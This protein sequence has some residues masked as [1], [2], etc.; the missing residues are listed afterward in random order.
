MFKFHKK[1]LNYQQERKNILVTGGAGFI[2][3]HLCE[4]LVKKSNVICVDNFS[5]SN[6]RNIDS[7]LQNPN[8]EFIK[9]NIVEPLDFNAFPELKKF[10]IEVFGIQEIYNLACPTSAKNFD[11]LIVETLLTSSLGLKNI[12]DI[13]LKYEA[14]LLHTSSA[15]VYG[16]RASTEKIKED[17]LGSVNFIGPRSSYDEGKR[18]AETIIATYN[19]F[20]KRNFK[21]AR[22]FRTYGPRLALNDGQ[23]I[24]DFII[25]ALDNKDLIIYGNQ[26]FSTTLCFVSDIV[27]GLIKLMDSELTMPVNLGSDIDVLL[28]KV[29]EDIIKM[30]NSTSKII[31]K[32]RLEFITPLCLP[33]INLAKEKLGWYPLVNLELG[34]QKTL[35]YIRAHKQLLSGLMNNS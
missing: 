20:Y 14:K 24:S 18:F 3:S 6:Q 1:T 19:K 23:M 27:D 30:T 2:G 4:N 5:T 33:D 25:N 26:A 22:I 11:K 16:S 9:Y 34:L 21:I 13:A 10:K 15:V 31:Y 17:Y 28:S 7:L 32:E 35:N 12:L 8:F 29:A